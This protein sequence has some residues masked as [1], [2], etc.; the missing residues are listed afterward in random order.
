MAATNAASKATQ[1]LFDLVA[2]FTL[3]SIINWVKLLCYAHGIQALIDGNFIKLV[4]EF[5]QT[6]FNTCV[7]LIESRDDTVINFIVDSAR[8]RGVNP[9]DIINSTVML[10]LSIVRD[11]PVEQLLS[12]G[13][14]EQALVD[15]T[16]YVRDEIMRRK[17][18]NPEI[19]HSIDTGTKYEYVKNP[20]QEIN[21][22][23]QS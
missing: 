15:V 9:I 6:Y 8:E 13:N 21:I 2:G 1:T 11:M 12:S 4:C 22:N 10:S 20:Y 17:M 18:E 14:I 3:F 5:A 23:M 16:N 19:E 7:D